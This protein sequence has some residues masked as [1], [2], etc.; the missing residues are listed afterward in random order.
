MASPGTQSSLRVAGVLTGAVDAVLAD[1]RMAAVTSV[2]NLL[3]VIPIV[4]SLPSTL[5]NGIAVIV[6]TKTFDEAHGP[7]IDVAARA[8]YLAVATP[9]AGIVIIIG[10]LLLVLPGI[11]LIVRFALYPAAVMVDDEGPLEGLSASGDRTKGHG[12]TV[13]GSLLAVFVPGILLT[14]V[15][16]LAIFGFRFPA[17]INTM[18]FSLESVSDTLVLR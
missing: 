7:E 1:P 11:Y 3:G 12:L 13:F 8:V 15:L 14:V 4:G 18:S 16:Y 6:A 9:V 2:G 5:G 10:L 17:R